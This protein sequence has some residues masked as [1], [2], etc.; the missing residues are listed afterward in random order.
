MDDKKAAKV[1]LARAIDYKNCFGSEAGKRVLLDLMKNH[2]VK[3]STFHPT[4]VNETV[5]MEGERN[6]VLRILNK[7]DI[8]IQKLENF[9]TKGKSP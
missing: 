8:D 5:F 2:H 6:V 7:L 9:I 4:N 1:I 3:S